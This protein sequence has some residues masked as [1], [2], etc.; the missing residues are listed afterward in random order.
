M[1]RAVKVF[2]VPTIRGNRRAA[3]KSVIQ[4]TPDRTIV[5]S[6]FGG[7]LDIVRDRPER[8]RPTRPV[9]E[10]PRSNPT[11]VHKAT[12]TALPL[13]HMQPMEEQVKGQ[14]LKARQFGLGRPPV[15]TG[16]SAAGKPRMKKHAQFVGGVRIT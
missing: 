16:R 10:L 7:G 1:T 12:V 15:Q 5:Q 9:R 14:V 11:P 8:E 2:I 13:P 4:G 3:R 6:E